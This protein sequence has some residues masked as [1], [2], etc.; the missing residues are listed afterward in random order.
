MVY[1]IRIEGYNQYLLKHH[2]CFSLI[3]I[4]LFLDSRQLGVSVPVAR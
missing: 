4:K 2:D 1:L 3:T